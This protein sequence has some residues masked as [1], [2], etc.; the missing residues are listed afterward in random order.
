M[1]RPGRRGLRRAG[2][3]CA[4]LAYVS[5]L[6][7]LAA[8]AYL[9]L[10]LHVSFWHPSELVE[11]FYPELR[12]MRRAPISRA[13]AP[14]DVLVLGAS[15]M[16]LGNI[17]ELLRQGLEK[18]LGRE[19]RIHS[20]AVR[21]HT[22]RD[23]YMKYARL[24]AQRFDLVLVYH[25]IN[26]VR[27][28]NCPAELFRDDYS[29]YSW[30]A[31]VGTLGEGREQDL[32]ALPMFGRLAWVRV[33]EALGARSFVPTHRPREEWLDHGAEIK[34]GP[35]FAANLGRIVA[36]AAE[37]GDPLV[38]MTFAYHFPADYDLATFKRRGLD[39]GA[40][41]FP[42][43]LWGRPENVVRG[44]EEHNRIIRALHAQHPE[45]LFVDQAGLMPKDG[46]HFDDLCHLT[47]RGQRRWVANLIPVVP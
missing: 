37:R 24:G 3:L 16:A 1:H 26:E 9:T 6:G 40:H 36:L 30:Y 44:I 19:V 21:A 20:L 45:T 28:N 27:A 13:D 25:A 5:L 35:A 34:T 46:R 11:H 17:E 43:E 14:Y 15:V 12:D 18:K 29:H 32:L 10:A 33:L 4:Y 8:R 2:L 42:A 41:A 22:S 31:S 39:Y 23:S 7:E 38:L 47:E